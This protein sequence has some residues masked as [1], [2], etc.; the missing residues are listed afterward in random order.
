[1]THH[2]SRARLTST[3]PPCG[4]WKTPLGN[5]AFP[6][7]CHTGTIVWTDRG[8]RLWRLCSVLQDITY[9]N[10]L[11]ASLKR[12]P[13]H[14]VFSNIR[15][16]LN[17][18][19][20]SQTHSQRR[21]LGYTSFCMH[22]DRRVYRV[23]RFQPG[24]DPFIGHPS[25]TGKMPFYRAPCICSPIHRDTTTSMAGGPSAKPPHP[26]FFGLAKRRTSSRYLG[27][28]VNWF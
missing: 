15:S 7:Q 18:S 8:H 27:V 25:R 26:P 24:L 1:M 22:G 3:S 5:E 20:H 17:L 9:T 21:C 4:P 23:L 10:S 16:S 19:R 14:R 12:E 28:W 6:V 2:L 11:F 13:V